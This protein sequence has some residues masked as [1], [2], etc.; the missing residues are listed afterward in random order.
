MIRKYFSRALF[1]DVL[2]FGFNLE[3]EAQ[4]TTKLWRSFGRARALVVI[5]FL[6]GLTFNVDAQWM[7]IDQNGGNPDPSAALEVSDTSRGFL[8]PRL[9]TTQMNAITAPASGLLI[10]NTTDSI[11]KYYDGD[12][13]EN[14]GSGGINS[15]S[16]GLSYQ[17]ISHSSTSYTL[18]SLKFKATDYA[19]K[20]DSLITVDNSG[21]WTNFIVLEKSIISIQ[22]TYFLSGNGRTGVLLFGDYISVNDGTTGE[23]NETG[24][25]FLAEAGDTIS[26]SGQSVNTSAQW[27]MSMVARSVENQTSTSSSTIS[28]VDESGIVLIKDLKPNSSN[29]GGISAGSWVTRDV[30]TMEGDTSYVNLSSNQFTLAQG[31]FDIK[32]SAPAYHVGFHK[33][34]LYNVTNSSELEGGSIEYS[35]TGSNSVTKSIGHAI[36]SVDTNTTFR[37]EHRASTTNP[38]N[39]L[40]VGNA[41]GFGDNIY[42]QVK[43]TKLDKVFG[44]GTS[45]S[46][47]STGTLDE[48][49]FSAR[50][51]GSANVISSSQNFI[52][53]VSKLSTGFYKVNFIGGFFNEHPSVQVTA[54]SG[55]NDLNYQVNANDISKD[56]VKVVIT[57]GGAVVDT[58]FSLTVFRQGSDYRYNTSGASASALASSSDTL[59]VIQDADN[60]TK[61]Q[62]EETADEDVIRFNIE[63]TEYFVMD[64]G[65]I[66]VL[67]TGNTIAIG[68]GAGESDDYTNNNNVFIGK[69]AGRK[70]NTGSFNFGA[71]TSALLNNTIGS[72]NVAIGFQSLLD[73]SVGGENVAIGNFALL[74]NTSGKSTA[75]GLGASQR[76]TT[77]NYNV[78]LG[79]KANAF[80]L[81]GAKNTIL[82]A[83]AGYLGSNHNKSGN[84]MIGFRA[85]YNESGSN[86]LYIHNDST[87]SPLVYGD[88][89][90]DSLRFGGAVRIADELHI[91]GALR[92][93]GNAD[94]Q[95][96]NFNTSGRNIL[97]LFSDVGGT[98]AG[99]GI[100]I[101]GGTDNTF[102]HQIRF[103]AGA[104]QNGVPRILLDSSGSVGIG[105]TSPAANLHVF[106]GASGQ[107]FS[108]VNGLTVENNGSNNSFFVFQ[109]ATDGGGKS[110]SITNAGNVGIGT[111]TPNY[112]LDVVG[113]INASLTVRAAGIALISDERYK[114]NITP[115]KNTLAS[116]ELLNGVYHDWDTLNFPE[117][118]FPKGKAIG[119]IAQDMQKIYPE[120]VYENSN[121]YLA[122]DYAKFSTVLLEAIK[123]Q[124]KLIENLQ[125]E[126]RSLKSSLDVQNSQLQ[127]INAKLELIQKAI[128]EGEAKK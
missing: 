11:Y 30:N 120:L 60:D 121:G 64:T 67:N 35:L 79:Y 53:S 34:R 19:F 96:D 82:G 59:P 113:N 89:D 15:S 31:V 73:N 100:N 29:G 111:T 90:N 14:I 24:V 23:F 46:G 65:R 5:M 71:G 93:E 105:T 84:V 61:I 20:G 39:G 109:T 128:Y 116:L 104:S 119:V 72:D 103:Y 50:I 17:E 81:Q 36:I 63:G 114:V 91:D 110:F 2:L 85:G 69:N 22:S 102:P 115:L 68:E 78:S 87:S 41:T 7:L 86:K 48:N 1:I 18:S 77:G 32:W 66:D 33:S 52:G 127:E 55:N 6:V 101:F 70:T 123:E 40:G 4:W 97:R 57:R 124:Q 21:S 43:I 37:I 107:T 51:S 92:F 12:S 10:F 83:E 95:I 13:W 8:P 27:I 106:G 80:N 122:V 112:N 98:N 88:F 44:S 16:S 99:A 38:T 62:V 25:T 49:V 126:N 28:S 26:I 125:S 45:S 47:S 108:N 74:N 56:S 3:L 54:N 94:A 9:T 58:S 75:V 117:E 118:Q 42:T 76:N